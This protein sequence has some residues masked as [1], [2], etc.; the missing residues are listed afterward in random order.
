M[1]ERALSWAL[2]S[3]VRK[4]VAGGSGGWLVVAAAAGAFKVL[5]RPEKNA[6]GS[7]QLKLK[8]G[9]RYTI[10]CS[11]EPIRGK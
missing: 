6:K 1:I 10:I 3:G 11:E 9:E 5:R 8:P 4:G 2:R 7:I